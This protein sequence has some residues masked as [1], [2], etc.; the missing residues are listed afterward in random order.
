MHC[1]VHYNILDNHRFFNSIVRLNTEKPVLP[2]K[3]KWT[4]LEN[5]CRNTFNLV[6]YID[7]YIMLISS[8]MVHTQARKRMGAH[9]T[10]LLIFTTLMRVHSSTNCHLQGLSWK[11][12]RTIIKDRK[13]RRTGS[14]CYSVS[15]RMGRTKDLYSLSGKPRGLIVSESFLSTRLTNWI[16][17]I[18]YPIFTFFTWLY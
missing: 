14:R 3:N 15:I 10:V 16:T 18:R 7:I 4:V 12:T 6:F 9:H 2:M 11:K 5:E 1:W 13:W 8:W 17:A